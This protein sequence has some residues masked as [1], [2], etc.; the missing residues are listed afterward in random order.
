MT[1][2]YNPYDFA[3]PVLDPTLFA[4]RKREIDDIKYYL[5]Q[6]VHTRP[7][8]LAILGPQ[9][10][11]KTSL[12]NRAATEAEALGFL[13]VRLDLD[14]GDV[15]TPWCFFFKLVDGLVTAAAKSGAF[16]GLD[17]PIYQTYLDVSTNFCVPEDKINC[18][19]IFPLQY[20]TAMPSGHDLPIS[21]AAL[22]L[23]L[24][25]VR[26]EVNR[27]I[28]LLF[29]ESNVL[30]ESKIVLEKMRNL[31]M[32]TPGYMIFLAG[33]DD[34]FPLLN[35]V[36]SPI[37]RQFKKISIGAF[38]VSDDTAMCVS[39]PL[40]K[41]DCVPEDWLGPDAQG[42]VEE[43]HDL[44]SGR[45]YEIQLVCHI[46]FKRVQL[47]QERYM[48]LSLGVLKDVR[49]ELETSQDLSSR[50]MLENLDRLTPRD[51]VALDVLGRS[52]GRLAFQQLWETEYVFYGENRF[53]R[54]ALMSSLDD[55]VRL[56]LL[57]SDNDFVSF[58]GD[59]FDRVY[60]KYYA[61]EHG[62][63]L[64]LLTLSPRD[65]WCEALKRYVDAIPD[66]EVLGTHPFDDDKGV[67]DIQDA[68]RLLTGVSSSIDEA[69]F[70]SPFSLDL[71]TFMM[72]SARGHTSIAAR[73]V[74][75]SLP[76]AKAVFCLAV[77]FDAT[78][79]GPRFAEEELQ[80]LQSR[81]EQC[82]GTLEIHDSTV[83]V[84]P[85][86]DLM[87]TITSSSSPWLTESLAW[88]HM[89]T[90]LAAYAGSF[91][92][93]EKRVEALFHAMVAANYKKDW[94]VEYANDF[95]YMLLASGEGGDTAPLFR[96][97]LAMNCKL[98]YKCLIEY[99]LAIAL[100]KNGQLADSVELLHR[101][102]AVD[103][104]PDSGWTILDNCFLVRANVSP[105]GQLAYEEVNGADLFETATASLQS[106]SQALE[107][108]PP[109][110]SSD[111]TS[112][113]CVDSLQTN[114]QESG[115]TNAT[116]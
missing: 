93:P 75:L 59:E 44:S 91:Q 2:E 41:A 115:E 18:P 99:N 116:E 50:P 80:L 106:I 45:P 79:A 53:T 26:K 15:V 46:C 21:D 43:I 86:D 113:R 58:A 37:V 81:L 54:S 112:G 28:A 64:Q 60:I 9:R 1:V 89:N 102:L 85:P 49:S 35:E 68:Y 62:Q 57:R 105:E 24:E 42:F 72:G 36:Y 114:P 69:L 76:W 20:A 111:D 14:D 3:N 90:A 96:S 5:T 95:A 97:A 8:H 23:D 55:L 34:L 38:P 83:S 51:F 10:S 31:F 66:V 33:T 47:G 109:Q 7:Q 103:R 87:K 16:G 77:P 92:H 32:N 27:P 13:V 30:S 25:T 48:K 40:K 98:E 56:G 104:I 19:L 67:C 71:Y 65:L 94:A 6:A 63:R 52:N 4:G 70:S 22:K 17:G 12:L 61:R 74:E 73:Q 107:A 29:D 78:M 110:P 108:H 100:S 11:G 88:Q 82:E 39:L 101:I 84:V